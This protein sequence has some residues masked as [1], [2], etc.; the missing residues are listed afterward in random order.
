MTKILDI[1]DLKHLNII[2]IYEKYTGKSLDRGANII[3][4]FHHD[5]NPSMKLYHRSNDRY[6]HF[7]CFGCHKF[8]HTIDLVMGLT[9]MNFAEACEDMRA[10]FAVDPDIE[11]TPLP[12]EIIQY[13][14]MEEDGTDFNK[15]KVTSILQDEDGDVD[16]IKYYGCYQYFTDK[17]HQILIDRKDNYFEK[18]GITPEVIKEYSLGVCPRGTVFNVPE[19][20]DYV[21]AVGILN[22][23]NHISFLN[24][25]IIPI[26]DSFGIVG[27][28]GRAID[29]TSKIRYINTRG[30]DVF[31][32]SQLL[33]NWNKAKMYDT[34]Y[35][36]EGTMD[37]LSLIS[38]GIP[39][40]VAT[41][42]TA[43]SD[44]QKNMLK[45]KTIVYCFDDD[46]AGHIALDSLACQQI[47]KTIKPYGYK[48]FNDLLVNK[49]PKA[50][51]IATEQI[52]DYTLMRK[53]SHIEE[54]PPLKVKKKK[55]I[56]K[57]IFDK[58]K[59]KRYNDK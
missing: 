47:I 32:K 36:V 58:F 27:F 31:I 42:G 15:K 18:R 37:A 57:K 51:K 23:Y 52:I 55:N 19:K 16:L 40:V 30:N 38:S 44:Y 4:P 33:F 45:G 3:C 1:D 34:I 2:K 35:L 54:D 20:N 17:F 21:Q 25:Y 22:E 13:D 12:P 9:G 49:G 7:Y 28:I 24:R 41:M 10:K 43:F 11:K 53:D 6:D 39:N 29:N 46:E 5:Q 8:G 56:I 50:V 59:K 14:E 26:K 48:D